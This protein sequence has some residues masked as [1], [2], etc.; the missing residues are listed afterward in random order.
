MKRIWC[1]IAAV[2]L[3]MTGCV[4][5]AEAQEGEIV[6]PELEI[7]S[8]EIPENEALA[9]I[10]EM[11]A[12]WNL[13]NTFD[14]Y[15]A[16][17]LQ[18]GLAYE[19]AWCGVKT[20]RVLIHGLKEAGFGVVRIP[21][22]WHNHLDADWTIDPAWLARV[23]EVTEWVLEE[24]MYAIVNI[25][26]DD[27]PD[28]YDPSA[29]NPENA[30]AYVRTIW[31]QI[32]EAFADLDGHLV[33]ECINEPRLKGT[34]YE[35]AWNAKNADCQAAMANIVEMNQVF[36]DTVRAAGGNN[37]D[38]YLM[39]PAYGAGPENACNSA[40]SL[41]ADSAENRIIVSVHAYYPYGFA[42]EQP[43]WDAFSL[44]NASLKSGI[45]SFL[46]KL[47][48]TF[49]SRGIP[50]MIGEFGAMEKN[51]N[52]QSRV[53]WVSWYVASA[54]ARGITCCW[55]DNNV[56][57]GQGERFGLMNRETGECVYPEILEAIMKYAE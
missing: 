10:R 26:H 14:A 38:R 20:T 43:G 33:F 51:G 21:V 49:V 18:D 13:G 35:W 15:D 27:S 40:F 48:Q 46:Q 4:C 37:T 42:L 19:T 56:F 17:W 5:C 7:E 2:A 25:H 8:K 3:L 54:R 24:G 52:L 23:R 29:A 30:R 47:Y 32:A 55:W 44:Q 53:N 57:S 36:V 34:E 9:M 39:V 22:S 12:G 31:A 41:P 1:I 16:S 45:A 6:I 28:Y 50:V 11:K